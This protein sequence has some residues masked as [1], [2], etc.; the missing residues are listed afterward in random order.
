M[1][2]PAE[3]KTLSSARAQALSKDPALQQNLDAAEQAMKSAHEAL[4][5]AMIAEDPS[6]AGILAKMESHHPCPPPPQQGGAS[7]ASAKRNSSN[8][9]PSSPSTNQPVNAGVSN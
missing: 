1:L 6:V 5:S 9:A 7:P 8:G 2:T 4:K 3:K